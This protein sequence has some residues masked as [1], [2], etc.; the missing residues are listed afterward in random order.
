[1]INKFIKEICKNKA[2]LTTYKCPNSKDFYEIVLNNPYNHEAVIT[3]ICPNDPNVYHAYTSKR[4]ET[5]YLGQRKLLC[6][7]YTCQPI[8]INRFQKV[9][10]ALSIYHCDNKTDCVSGIDDHYYKKEEMKLKCLPALAYYGTNGAFSMILDFKLCE[11][12]CDCD[13]IW[14][15]EG[16][17]NKFEHVYQCQN[18]TVIISVHLTGLCRLCE[19]HLQTTT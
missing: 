1:M 13:F 12:Y 8:G 19:H 14:D 16:L 18:S 10:S 17:C 5:T 3:S 11:G 6:S 2:N 7:R 4:L 9:Q 15:D